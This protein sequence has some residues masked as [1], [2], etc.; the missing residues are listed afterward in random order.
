LAGPC[1]RRCALL[2]QARLRLQS[3]IGHDT[4]HQS[5]W[6]SPLTDLKAP[7][8]PG[9]SP[10]LIS[11]GDGLN[12][13]APLAQVTGTVVPNALFFLRSNNP[14]PT[15]DPRDWR[16]RI[17]GRVKRPLS[18]DLSA[19]RALPS[20]TQEVWLECAGNS[21][22]RFDPP[23]E[24]NQ[25]DEQA[26]SNAVFTGVPLRTLLGQAGVED[27]AIE[28]VTTGY[29]ADSFQRGLPLEVALSPE[30]LLA[31]EMNGEPIPWPHGGPARLVVPRWAGIASVKWPARIEVVN[32]PFRGHFNA[33][34][35]IMVDANGRTL[36]T[37]REMPVKSIIAWPAEGE[38]VRPGSHTLFGFAWSGFGQVERVEVSDDAQRTWQAA[39]LTRGN[40]P[41]AWTRWE[42]E[43]NPQ[44][45]GPV[46]LSVRATDSAGN[47]QPAEVA[48]NKFGYQMNA[49]LTRRVTVV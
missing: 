47:T 49:I 44:S 24:G 1:G 8:Y 2:R 36:R 46:T 11:L 22:R 5:A 32:T 29:D 31:F 18:I 35:Y 26:V 41:L 37:V 34:R 23:G 42:F 48:W 12:F 25:W 43:W 45:A 16:L 28:V 20:Q 38:T 3:R 33:E 15:L 17:D 30:V 6:R 21:R 19:L 10:D 7:P 4:P 9:K 13:S 40:G 27:D 14:P 39:R